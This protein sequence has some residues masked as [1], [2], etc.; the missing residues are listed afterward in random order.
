MVLI[1]LANVL[2]GITKKKRAL[3]DYEISKNTLLMGCD[4]CQR[5]C[6]YNKGVNSNKLEAFREKPTSYVIIKDLFD[7]T[8]K[9]FME[10]YGKHAYTWRGKTLLLLRNARILLQ[11]KKHKL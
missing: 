7:L 5:V 6:P 9:E 1:G 8:N 4:I 3:T 10:K 11:T 2:V